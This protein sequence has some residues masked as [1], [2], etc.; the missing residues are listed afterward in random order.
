MTDI[1][2]L[3]ATGQL[4]ALESGRIGSLDLLEASVARNAQVHARINAV[5]AQD[6]QRARERARAMDDLR[7]KGEVVGPLAGLPMTVK[8]TFD[9]EL[10]AN[11]P[12]FLAGLGENV[13]DAGH[14]PN[15]GRG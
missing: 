5:V 12:H 14:V 7:A 15:Q 13:F 1:L 3:D 4:A 9:V 8:D 2:C 6:L 11:G 10:A